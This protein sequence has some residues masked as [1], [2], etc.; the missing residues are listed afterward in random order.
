V[1]LG[2]WKRRRHDGSIHVVSPSAIRDAPHLNMYFHRSDEPSPD[3]LVA[4]R[5]PT[6]TGIDAVLQASTQQTAHQLAHAIGRALYRDLF[7][8]DELDHAIECRAGSR[9]V[10]IA[11]RAVALCLG[12]SAGTK[13]GSEDEALH[14]LAREFGEPLVNV[15]G[16]AGIVDYEPDFL[17]LRYRIIVEIDGRPHQDD[18]VTKERDRV[19]DELLRSVGWIV[20]RIHYLRVW[21]DMPGVVR[22]V[23]AAF[24]R[25]D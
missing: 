13:S 6:S 21:R 17:W 19:R 16:A 12:G 7:T 22:E 20:V 3:L 23:R 2:A 5:L 9:G 4:N 15:M 8:I 11:R 24:A 10:V 25:R 14:R 1:N 18:P